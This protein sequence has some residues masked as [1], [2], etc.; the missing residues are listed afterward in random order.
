LF[1]L[2]SEEELQKK[3]STILECCTKMEQGD[4]QFLNHSIQPLHPNIPLALGFVIKKVNVLQFEMAR[5]KSWL[6]FRIGS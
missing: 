4:Y 5:S 1:P 6:G 2:L 3:Y